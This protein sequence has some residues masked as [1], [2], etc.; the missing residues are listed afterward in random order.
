MLKDNKR[1]TFGVALSPNTTSGAISSAPPTE[2]NKTASDY[3]NTDNKPRTE[4]GAIW[5]SISKNNNEFLN[6]RLK[7]TKEVLTQLLSSTENEEVNVSFV[8]FPNKTNDGISSRP[9]YRIYEETKRK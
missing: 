2:F 6:I 3:A 8:A 5:K 9:V 4:I 7:L 1:S